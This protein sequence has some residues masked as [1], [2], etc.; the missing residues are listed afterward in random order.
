MMDRYDVGNKIEF[1]GMPGFR[2]EVLEVADCEIDTNRAEPHVQY[3]IT[4]PEGQS[5]WLCAYDV[6]RV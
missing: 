5:D 1:K 3:R 2:M 6:N 4:D